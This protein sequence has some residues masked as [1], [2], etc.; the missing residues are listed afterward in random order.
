[1]RLRNKIIIAGALL[2]FVSLTILISCRAYFIRA[3]RVPTGAMANTIVPGDCL[4]ANRLFGE[5]KRGDIVLFKYPSE[6]AVSYVSRVV[7][8]PGET[9]HVQGTAIF[10][11]D[12]QIPEQR[13]YVEYP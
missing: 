2:V 7:G 6:P 3:V 4:F 1:M 9:I 8:L 10:I 13:V 12:K 5:V 11:N